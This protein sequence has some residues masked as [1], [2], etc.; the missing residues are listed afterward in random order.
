MMESMGNLNKDFPMKF[1]LTGLQ[2]LSFLKYGETQF[3]NVGVDAGREYL[4]K[5]MFPNAYMVCRCY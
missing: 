4:A 5:R 2:V 3:I 1:G